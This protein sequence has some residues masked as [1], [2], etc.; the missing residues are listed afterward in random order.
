[1]DNVHYT[2]MITEACGGRRVC[3]EERFCRIVRTALS[4]GDRQDWLQQSAVCRIKPQPAG[5]WACSGAGTERQTGRLWVKSWSHN[6]SIILN[7]MMTAEGW[8]YR[9]IGKR[10]RHKSSYAS[11]KAANTYL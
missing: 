2:G 10:R 4:L 5:C 3:F 1:M 6:N 9:R 8:L 11:A 7:K